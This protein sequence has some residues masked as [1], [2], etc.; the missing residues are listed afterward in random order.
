[1]A[2]VLLI[3]HGENDYVK[4]GRLAGRLQGIHLN[5]KGH[6]Q[7]RLV[8]EKL[9]SAPIK[10]VYSSPLERAVETA[11][12]LAR[13]LGL[14]VIIRQGLVETDYGDWQEKTV[15]GLS[16]LKLWRIV[17]SR[18]SL[19]RFPNGESFAEAQQRI[20]QE[21]Q[22]LSAQH[23]PKDMIACFS[24]AD[25][26]KLAVAYFLGLPLDFFQRLAISPASVTALHIGEA[27]S[28]LITM[29]YDYMFTLSTP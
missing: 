25:P 28:Q 29:N 23:D 2:I 24:H 4:K 6:C 20:C 9:C 11:E 18:P 12:P 17:Q 8:A 7:A 3:R 5:E 10:A 22:A 13:G 15:K 27:S 26:I 14:E 21:I 19:F 16:R 1:M